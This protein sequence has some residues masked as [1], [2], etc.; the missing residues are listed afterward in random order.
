MENYTYTNNLLRVKSDHAVELVPGFHRIIEEGTDCNTIRAFTLVEKTH[1]EVSGGYYYAWYRVKD[2]TCEYDKAAAVSR[3]AD[4][5]ALVAGIT[6]VTLA[7]NG[8]IDEVTAGEHTD[9]FEEWQTDMNYRV[10]NLR[11]Y[12]GQLY[13]CI[14]A[15]A[16]QAGWEPNAAVSLW[17]KAANPAEE[18][19][20]WS[21]PIGAADAYQ[22]GDKVS[23]NGNRWVS[24]EDNNVWEP[25]VYGWESLADE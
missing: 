11:A 23:H 1:E 9:L 14:Q 6:F 20:E 16:S 15:H 13:K 2:Y 24:T 8:A 21:Q 10:G 22:S 3:K 17:V 12:A 5:N 19:P 18:W 4:D 25:G 7:E